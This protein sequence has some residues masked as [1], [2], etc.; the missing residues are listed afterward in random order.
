M[1]EEYKKMIRE[2]FMKFIKKVDVKNNNKTIGAMYFAWLEA[3]Q[4]ADERNK[5]LNSLYH[6]ANNTKSIRDE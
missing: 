4:Q 2:N 5:C 3:T 1:D 6:M